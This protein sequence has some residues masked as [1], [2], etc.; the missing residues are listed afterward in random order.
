[1]GKVRLSEVPAPPALVSGPPELSG[2][3]S[4]TCHQGS[5]TGSAAEL[6]GF[7]EDP[8]TLQCLT[9]YKHVLISSGSWRPSC[10]PESG[11]Y[12]SALDRQ[13]WA[14]SRAQPAWAGRAA[15]CWMGVRSEKTLGALALLKPASG[16]WRE[17]ACPLTGYPGR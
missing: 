17:K 3:A 2:E 6:L 10:S 11:A 5:I 16:K 14:A 8:A 13:A 4:G 7:R 1:M 12:S 15:G 9:V